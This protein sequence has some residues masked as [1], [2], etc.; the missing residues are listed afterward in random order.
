MIRNKIQKCQT[1]I[2]SLSD[3]RDSP[4]IRFFVLIEERFQ[5][6]VLLELAELCRVGESEE[7]WCEL[8]EPLRIDCCHLSHVL[9][10]CLHELVINNPENERI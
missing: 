3:A 4:R 9:L 7:S 8:Y 6:L 2:S 1:L 5:S 10:R